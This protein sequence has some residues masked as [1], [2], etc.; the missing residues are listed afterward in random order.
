MKLVLTSA[1]LGALFL[2]SGCAT[3]CESVSNAYNQC[4]LDQRVVQVDAANFC[5]MVDALN[6]RAGGNCGQLWTAHLQ[7]WQ[8]HISSICDRSFTDCDASATAWDDCVTTYCDN[9]PADKYDPECQGG[10]GF[11]SLSLPSPFSS[12]F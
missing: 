2:V 4:K 8:Q 3:Q 1:L 5:G 10:E 6:Q 9:L 7:C 11:G 12:D